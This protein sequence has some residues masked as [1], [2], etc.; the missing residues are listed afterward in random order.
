MGRSNMAEYQVF[1]TQG[2]PKIAK[3]ENGAQVLDKTIS[4]D[5]NVI[6]GVFDTLNIRLCVC[7]NQEEEVGVHYKSGN[8]CA[9]VMKASE[10][11]LM[12]DIAAR[13]NLNV[14]KTDT[15]QAFLNWEG[16]DL[17]QTSRLVAR[18]SSLRICALIDAVHVRNS[19]S[20]KT[21]ARANFVMDGR[22]IMQS[23]M[24]KQCS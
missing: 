1:L 7:S 2:T 10:V 16:G 15:K 4:A 19:A 8:L 21:M 22:S 6:N 5:H 12:M 9:Q 14:F 13:E 24:R 17:Y 18:A 3:P 11:Q 20:R 23:T